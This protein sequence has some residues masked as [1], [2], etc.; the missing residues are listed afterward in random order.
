M[1]N[2]NTDLDSDRFDMERTPNTEDKERSA[3]KKPQVAV[4]NAGGNT[5]YLFSFIAGLIDADPAIEMDVIDGCKSLGLYDQ[6]P[7]VRF[8]NLRSHQDHYRPWHEKVVRIVAYYWRLVSYAVHSEAKIFH[9]QWNN[10]FDFID[11]VILI[12]VYRML[13]KKLFYT[14]HN[15]NSAARANRDTWWN[16]WTLKCMYG[17]FEKVFVHTEGLAKELIESFT[18][19]PEK[20]V[21]V[22][23]GIN[24][25][26]NE[27][28]VSMAEAREQLGIPAAAR[29]LLFFGGIREYKG[30]DLLV[31]AFSTLRKEDP[32]YFLVVA[33]W[34]LDELSITHTAPAVRNLVE[35]ECCLAYLRFVE[36]D[37]I[38]PLFAASDCIVM[39]YK[40]L[41]QSGVTFLAYAYGLPVI[42]TRVGS[43]PLDIEEGTTGL[44]CEP[45]SPVALAEAIRRYF[46][47]DLCEKATHERNKLAA[48]MRNRFSWDELARRTLEVDRD[49]A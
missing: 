13:G 10:K 16:R 2:L 44:L 34:P 22:P 24:A 30:L 38:G 20:V 12:W 14:A 26:V 27:S 4:L 28:G 5:D 1:P 6:M 49:T 3:S 37:E 25:R 19:A 29:V 8:F 36:D 39:P 17:N 23:R 43:L 35:K 47:H 31:D 40:A 48:D 46:G 21:V 33:G 42:A 41:F 45:H 18:V 15:I 7:S 9:I 11:R 32:R